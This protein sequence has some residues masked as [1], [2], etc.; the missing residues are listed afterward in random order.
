M[1]EHQTGGKPLSEAMVALFPD[2]YL[3][4]SAWMC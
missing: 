4:H 2:A 1:A 3:H